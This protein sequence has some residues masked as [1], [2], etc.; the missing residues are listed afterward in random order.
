MKG[1]LRKLAQGFELTQE[2]VDE[3]ISGIKED[4]FPATQVAGF[5]MGLL[6]KGPTTSEIAAIARAMRRVCVPIAPRVDG[7]LT[8]T[9]GTGGGLTTFNVSTANALLSAA[10]GIRIAKHGSRSISASSGSADVLEALGIPVDLEPSQAERLIEDAGFSFLYAPNFHPVMMKVF[11][12]E[13]DLGIKTIFFTIIGPLINPADAK[14]HVLGVY[15]P[16]LVDQVGEVAIELGFRHIIVVHGV[17][18]V[19]EISLLGET[20]VVEVKDGSLRRYTITPEDFGMKRC[21]I[22]EIKGGDPQYNARTI[23]DIFAGKETGPKLDMLLLNAA[24]TFVVADKAGSFEEG[25]E[26]ARET[27]ESGRAMAK[28]EEIRE[29]SRRIN[30]NVPMPT[31]SYN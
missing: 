24:A 10:A 7:D 11:G 31:I 15:Q 23:Q 4:R 2:D 3:V 13:H 28:L 19:D 27:I 8:D 30:G 14:R 12:P 20:M 6:M 17:D 22:E 9:C 1:I 26:M 25:I 18:G 5:L 21:T 29:I 16:Q